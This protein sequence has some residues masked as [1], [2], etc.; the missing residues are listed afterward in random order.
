MKTSTKGAFFLASVEGVVPGPYQD[1]EGIWTYGIGHTDMAGPPLPSR[2]T[3]GYPADVKKELKR[4]FEVY[5]K[6]LQAYEE[7]VNKAFTCELTQYQ[8]D[9]AVSFHYNT[10]AIGRA[11]WVKSMNAG[12][13][14]KAVDQIMNWQT[15]SSIIERRRKEQHLFKTGDYGAMTVPVWGIQNNKPRGLVCT[16]TEEEFMTYYR[17][18]KPKKTFWGWLRGLTNG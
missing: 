16:L 10:G 2:M 3:R 4:V 15:P 1:S 11:Y 14:E 12:D 8:F 18:T 6:D 7:D 5:R 17:K 9:A 13:A